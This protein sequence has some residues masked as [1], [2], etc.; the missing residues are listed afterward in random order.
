LAVD[1]EV[2]AIFLDRPLPALCAIGQLFI[3]ASNGVNE[4]LELFVR[5][6]VV[7]SGHV[8]V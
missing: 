7:Q 4:L 6:I 8:R 5:Q 3:I 2:I 1:I